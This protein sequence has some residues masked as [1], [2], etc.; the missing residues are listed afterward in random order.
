[1]KYLD[2]VPNETP[3]DRLKRIPEVSVYNHNYY[4][5]SHGKYS[6]LLL[7]G[8]SDDDA[9]TEWYLIRGTMQPLFLGYSDTRDNPE[10]IFRE[11]DKLS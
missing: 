2:K 9:S 11:E 7:Y 3:V 6:K 5:F 1:M 4:S 10:V 8:V